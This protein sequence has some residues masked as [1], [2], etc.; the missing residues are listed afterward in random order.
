MKPRICV[1]LRAERPSDYP[2]LIQ[3]AEAA[4]ADLIEIRLDY[5]SVD[6]SDALKDLRYL[7]ER[8]SAS[9]IVT[10]RAY[11]QGG[12]RKQNEDERIKILMRAAEAGFEYVDVEL[13]TPKIS[14]VVEKIRSNGSKP[15]ISFHIFDRTPSIQEMRSFIKSELEAGADV[16]KLITFAKSLNDN[17]KCLRLLEDMGGSSRIVCF[18]MG[19]KGLISRVL[20]PICGG[21]FTFASL[22]EGAA[23]APGQISINELKML[24]EKLGVYG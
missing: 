14:S 4:G 2:R 18:A 23:T 13:T 9:M 1:S 17:F 16:C 11:E 6:P 15:L 20:S 7:V 22:M 5:L 19:R 8:T 24:Y 12:G 3:R 21:Y 10:N